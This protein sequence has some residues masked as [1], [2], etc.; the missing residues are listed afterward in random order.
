MTPWDSPL[1]EIFL[2]Q[3]WY[4][5]LLHC[6]QESPKTD[7]SIPKYLSLYI[8]TLSENLPIYWVSF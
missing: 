1:Q 8:V 5:G 3:G 7:Y 4:L 6:R 2:T